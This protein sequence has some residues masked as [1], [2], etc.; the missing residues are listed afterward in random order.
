MKFK[1]I[2]TNIFLPLILLVVIIVVGHQT[3]VQ[4]KKSARKEVESSLLASIDITESTFKI[5]ANEAL[6]LADITSQSDFLQIYFTNRTLLINDQLERIIDNRDVV[7]AVVQD[8][9]GIILEAT[10]SSLTG[11][12]FKSNSFSYW[13]KVQS[14]AGAVLFRPYLEDFKVNGRNEFILVSAPVYINEVGMVGA[15]TLVYD[16]KVIFASIFEAARVGVTGETYA[17]DESALLISESRFLD[18][19]EK[20]G[21]L[22]PGQSAKYNIRLF[23][24][25]KDLT[26]S[27]DKSFKKVEL[28]RMV[29]S[30]LSD[31]IGVD[32][33]GYRDYRGVNVVGAWVW[34]N[35]YGFGFTAEM[36]YNEAY[37]QM[38][39]LE[40]KFKIIYLLLTAFL[41]ITLYLNLEGEKLKSKLL[42]TN[43][44]L[45]AKTNELDSFFDAIDAHSIIS[46]A[47]ASGKITFVN[48]NFEDVSKFGH[49]ELIGQDHRIINSE[50]HDKEFFKEMWDTIRSKN[51]WHGLIKNKAKDGSIYWVET[52]IFPVL[53]ETDE[54]KEYIA[55]RTNVTDIKEKQHELQRAKKEAER[56]SNMR[57]NF[58]ANVSHE[59]RT[60]LNAIIGFLTVLKDET[61]DNPSHKEKFEIVFHAAESL[62]EIIN[63]VLDFSR[64]EQGK[65]ELAKKECDL[66]LMLKQVYDLYNIRTKDRDV[67]FELK[68]DLLKKMY[69]LD[70]IKVKQVITNLVGNA[71]KFTSYGMVR[72]DVKSIQTQEG[73]TDLIIIVSDTGRGIPG[74]KL[75]R[76]F[77]PFGQLSA[78]DVLYDSGVGLG[79][80][81][82]DGYVKL[83]NGD[84]KVTSEVDKGTSFTI[85]IPNVNVADIT[86]SPRLNES[87]VINYNNE[88]KALVVDD[89][90]INLKMMDVYLKKYGI[91][92][93]SALS[94]KEAIT[95]FEEGVFDIIFMDQLMPEMK[96]TEVADRIREFYNEVPPIVS[97]SAS[98]MEDDLKLFQEKFDG[99]MT[100]P[101]RKKE[102]EA[103]LSKLISKKAAS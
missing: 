65:I 27:R 51:T 14:A 47:D 13:N 77:T 85:T 69:I 18:D 40:Q 93:V 45:E 44:T 87:K 31:G 63:D 75:D 7:G 101:I 1:Q 71:I 9:N 6:H 10:Q 21:L 32:V 60:P 49:H 41:I 52:T 42:K 54:I 29:K 66:E 81:I 74:D 67:V 56:I 46:K 62:L 59:L 88:V 11:K 102:L 94:G 100:K 96:G 55:V 20:T 84:I 12:Q 43:K 25:G 26:Q 35:E 2:F 17:F 86:D 103:I 23:D 76:I 61:I 83:M 92:V 3:Q 39:I 90:A 68:T 15:V 16:P 30:A 64:L 37:S 98:T 78:D 24:P 33:R 70:M 28:T 91:Q 97:L 34:L 58:M 80:A 36:D 57:A 48:A 4:V 99:I 95:I 72:L 89:N 73:I 5:W 50:F 82:V 53:D 38:G 22:E 19:L 79:L 8:E